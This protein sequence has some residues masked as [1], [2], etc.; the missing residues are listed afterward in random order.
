M[1]DKILYVDKIIFLFIN[2]DCANPILDFI[3]P[4]WRHRLFW[5]P[6]YLFVAYFLI[7][8]YGRKGF[9][10]LLTLLITFAI[11]DVTSSH[12]IKPFV[13]RIRPCNAP[14]LL[15][16]V[17]MLVGCGAGFSFPS[18]HATNHFAFAVCLSNILPNKRK[19]LLLWSCLW[20]SSIAIAQVYVGVHYPIDVTFGSFL[21]I[22]IGYGVAK[23]FCKTTATL[24]NTGNL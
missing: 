16:M 14:D 15:G 3:F 13:E 17:R 8:E 1:L 21:G 18:A 5:V 23:I 19:Q 20:A 7:T 24:W 11:S 10:M 12:I 4:W 22:V 9:W 6:L 2:N